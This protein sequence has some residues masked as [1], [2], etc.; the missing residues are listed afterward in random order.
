MNEPHI[1]IKA[2]KN[3]K[4]DSTKAKEICQ[5]RTVIGVITTGGITKPAKV[6]FDKADVAWVENFP[7]SK[8]LN[9][10]GQEES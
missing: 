1:E 6:V 2:W 3:K 4:I 9:Q 8:L 5:K 7:E 10:E